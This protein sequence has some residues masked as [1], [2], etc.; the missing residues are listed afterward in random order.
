MVNMTT[1]GSSKAN[2]YNFKFI[3]V[4]ECLIM[5]QLQSKFSHIVSK[6]EFS[7]NLCVTT[8]KMTQ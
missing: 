8:I 1:T 6:A 3:V 5:T 4:I 2:L 7:C